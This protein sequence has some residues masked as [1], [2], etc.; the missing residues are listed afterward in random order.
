MRFLAFA[1]VSNK[2]VEEDGE[3]LTHEEVVKT[4]R[5]ITGKLNVIIDKFLQT[6]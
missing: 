1:G 6:V 3:A 4:M 5:S 2:A